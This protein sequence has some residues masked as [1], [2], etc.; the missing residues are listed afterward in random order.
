MNPLKK[1][2]LYTIGGMA[3]LLAGLALGF[4]A[5]NIYFEKNK[6]SLCTSPA[7]ASISTQQTI[8]AVALTP[9][10]T[11]FGRVTAKEANQFSITIQLSATPNA[12]EGDTGDAVVVKDT[13]IVIP[14]GPQDEFARMRRNNDGEVRVEKASFAD[15]TTNAYVTVKVLDAKKIIYLPTL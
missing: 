14:I 7:T 13:S 11:L 5:S 6:E 9:G 12:V 2:L 8:D 1:R 3:I 10:K 15:M 4:L